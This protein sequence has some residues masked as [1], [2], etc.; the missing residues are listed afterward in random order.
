MA[1]A[2]LRNA[3]QEAAK[4]GSLTPHQ[5]A[6]LSAL[7]ELL[8][9]EQKSRFTELWRAPQAAANPYAAL[10]PLLDF[11]AAGEG[12]Y[13]S[14]NRGHAGDTPGG[15][16]GLEE[17]TVAAVQ[18]AQRRGSVFAVGR[19]QFIPET[20]KIAI[21]A[22]G[23]Q[24]SERFSP[25]VQDWLAVALLLGGKRPR[26]RDYLLGKP[27]ALEDAQLELAKEWASI[28][29]PDGRGF[30]DGDSAGNRAVGTVGKVQAA[31]MAA[32]RGLAG[33][34]LPQ[35]RLPAQQEPKP[36]AKPPATISKTPHLR[37]SRSGK[38][39]S[40]GLEL[41]RLQ[42]LKDGAL[43]GEVLTVS[44]APSAQ[45]F[46]TGAQSRAG[47]LEPLPEGRYG[48][49]DIAWAGGR[50]NYGASWGPGLGPA[51]VPLSYLGPG[52]TQRSAIEIHYDSNA[53]VSPGTA[54]C[55]GMRSISDLQTL[56]GWLRDSDPQH[57]YADW[58]LGTCPAVK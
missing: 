2:T 28:P 17:L 31:L 45:N 13:N 42:Y 58:G 38:K 22:A 41:L 44:G 15:W 43:V 51:S 30:Y 8:S 12:D 33:R 49:A 29:G 1:H 50:N 34:T 53:S 24:P 26:L 9:E 19:Y 11:I 32:R 46:R 52:R 37:L 21:A 39:D 40:R 57:L 16:P 5:L 48:I 35:L 4:K 20:L 47:S 3:A 36:P 14:V 6:A 7:D 18:A 25:E 56:V 54:G 27:V 55:V 10:R 23:V